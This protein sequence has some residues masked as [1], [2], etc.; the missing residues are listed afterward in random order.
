[1]LRSLLVAIS[2]L[3]LCGHSGETRAQDERIRFDI[4]AGDAREGLNAFAAQSRLPLLYRASDLLN[5]R[6]NAIQ[7]EYTASEALEILVRDTGII[8]TLNTS[9]VVTIASA[10]PPEVESKPPPGKTILGKL[11]S[12]LFAD[13]PETDP[14]LGRGA[15]SVVALHDAARELEEVIVTGSRLQ[16]S[17]M[18]TSTP[19]TMVNSAE[20]QTMAP[21]TLIEGLVQLPQFL[22]N[23]TPQSQSYSSSGPAGASRVNLR[24]IGAQRNL[25]LL[26]GRRLVPSTRTGEVNIA[27]LPE[28]L[29]R[30]VDIVT[31][32]ASAAYGSD[33]VSG[34]VNFILNTDHAG[35]DA[36]AGGGITGLG[37]N[38]SREAGIVWGRAIGDRVHLVLSAEYYAADGIE[39]YADR[40]WFDSWAA[41][42]NPDPSGPREVIVPNV[43]SR[44]YTYGGLITDGPLR[45]TEFGPNGAPLPF[46]D[47]RY[48]TS[49]THAG[50]SGID[51]GADVYILPEQE[52]ASAFAYL[53]FAPT[54][55]LTLFAQGLYG[56][57]VTGFE[58]VPS[59]FAPPWSATIFSD[60]AFLPAS[61]RASMT[62]AGINS[63]TF[64]RLAPDSDLGSGFVTNTNDMISLTA[65]FEGRVKNVQVNGYYQYGRNTAVLHYDHAARIDRL[66]RALD[67]VIDPISGNIVCRSTLSFPGDG[68]VPLNAFGPDA[69]SRE[70]VAWITSTPGEHHQVVDQHILELTAQGAPFSTWAG[71]VVLV[72]GGGYRTE[73]LINTPRIEP[74]E[75]LQQAVVPAALAGYRG[76]PRDYENNTTLLER[77]AIR[78]GAAIAGD[79]DVWEV[80]GEAT[81]PLYALASDK[82]GLDLNLALRYA[83]YAGSGGIVAWKTGLEWRASD[84]LKLRWTRSRDVRAGTLAERFDAS[85]RGSGIRDPEQAPG[86]TNYAITLLQGGNPGVDPE[87][88]D[89]NTVGVIFEPAWL[90]GFALSVDYYDIR[91]RGAIALPGVQNIVDHCF[92][93]S[94]RH[95]ELVHRNPVTG[96]ISIVDNIFQNI[97]EV[98]TRGVDIEAVYRT[99]VHIFGGDEVLSARAFA[100]HLAEASATNPGQPRIDRAGQTGIEGG[101]PEWQLNLSI[102]YGAGPWSL[103]VQERYISGG[104][105]LA[106]W[107]PADISDPTVDTAFYTSL[108]MTREFRLGSGDLTLYAHI[109]NL[110]DADPPLAPDWRFSGSI[111]TNESLFDVL[112]R[113]FSAGVKFSF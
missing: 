83:D 91:V 47:G 5:A 50:G 2:L 1:M 58:A 32:G 53:K 41:I 98:R 67:A 48:V 112:G 37:D 22:N 62:T 55:A 105:Y 103:Y 97:D 33:A 101:G 64:G 40:D 36:H 13:K 12:L 113:R 60:N 7:G 26:N 65:G 74:P 25:I 82:R 90:N 59:L 96:L 93:G 15:G 39:G 24:G 49:L 23:D 107:G 78:P 30:R 75:L 6:T 68:C 21:T 108:Q 110:F 92:A 54:S 72:G 88:S 87:K 45:G 44:L 86:S 38:Q 66:Y 109:N 11:A 27:L 63:F 51:P 61:V 89:T 9:G 111:H 77:T 95:C 35:L 81:A 99:P 106:N 84:A 14:N 10:A 94:A 71:E 73:S 19:I 29:I 76:L 52:R 43:H 100:S 102:A 18:T 28:A 42:G 34:V 3:V 56:H 85:T 31:G 79:Y 69:P 70:A 20:L 8:A 104:T 4:P 80:F 57:G 17:G 16:G 46:S